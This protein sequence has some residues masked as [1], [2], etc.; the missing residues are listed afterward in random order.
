M[1]TKIIGLLYRPN[2]GEPEDSLN[3]SYTMQ[4]Y[5]M[6]DEDFN[7]NQTY[8]TIVDNDRVLVPVKA[9]QTLYKNFCIKYAKVLEI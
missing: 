5:T 4:S 2:Y 1:N 9:V 8:I 6:F 3:D 7:P